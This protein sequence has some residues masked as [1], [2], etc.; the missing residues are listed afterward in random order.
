MYRGIL[1]LTVLLVLYAGGTTGTL[2]AGEANRD[3]PTVP[4]TVETFAEA[5]THTMMQGAIALGA[6]GNWHHIRQLTP[7][8]QQTVVR[9]N[10][11]TLYSGAVLDLTEPATIVKPDIGDRYQSI[12]VINE[13]H[14]TKLALYEPGRYTLTKEDM[15]SRYVSITARTLVDA[16][17]PQD[18][19]E[20]HVA[21]DGLGIIQEHS[22]TFEVPNWDQDSLTRIRDALKVLGAHLGDRSRAYGPNIDEV[23]PVAH[24]IASADAWGGWKPENAVYLSFVPRQNDGK[25]PYVLTLRDVPAGKSAFWSISVYN[26]DGY[27]QENPHGKYVVNSR[28][29]EANA[30]GSVTIH[31]GGDPTKPNFL[32]VMESWNYMLRIYLPQEAY[33][34]GSWRAPEALPAD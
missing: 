2:A 24:V 34:D 33:F 30:D 1:G 22:G 26:A 5:E 31:F 4:V 3:E 8:N 29:A 12:M 19:A 13:G 10:Q 11:D 7:L 28:K 27:F 9:M 14:F 18:L 25:T 17:D 16:E 20:A 23:D 21:Q 15:G 32:P 6:S